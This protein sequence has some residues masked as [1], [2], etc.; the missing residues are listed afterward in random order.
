MTPQE[1]ADSVMQHVS[2]QFGVRPSDIEGRGR[3]GRVADAR[4][5]ASY[6]LWY[7][8]RWRYKDIG[9]YTGDR[10]HTTITNSIKVAKAMIQQDPDFK[11]RI[12]AVIAISE[13][14]RVGNG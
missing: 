1:R 13:N 5:A 4:H 12:D 10:H 7:V 8:Y 9:F 2:E 14:G 3:L 11:S 6:V